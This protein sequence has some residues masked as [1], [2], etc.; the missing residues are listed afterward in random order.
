MF[1]S[2]NFASGGQSVDGSAYAL[3]SAG[4]AGSDG[5]GLMNTPYIQDSMVFVLSNFTG[6]VSGISDVSF[7]YGSSSGDPNVPGVLVPE[8]SAAVLAGVGLLL[9][10]LFGRKRR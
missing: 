6:S 10:G 1:G 3:M 4:Y 7:Q 2:G 8:P 5:D 9:L